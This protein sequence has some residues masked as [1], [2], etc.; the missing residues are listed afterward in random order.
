MAVNVAGNL[1]NAAGTS[2]PSDSQSSV[3][4]G[5]FGTRAGP[6][7]L[8]IKAEDSANDDSIYNADDAITVTFSEPTNQ[9]SVAT[10]ANLNSLFT[11]SQVLGANYTGVWVNPFTLVITVKNS[12]GAEPPTVGSLT[13]TVKSSGNLKN[14]AGTSLAST[15]TSPVLSGSFGNKSGPSIISFVADD[16]DNSDSVFSNG[17]TLTI[18]FD[19]STNQ[20]SVATKADIDRLFTFSQSIGDDY[21]GAWV[22]PNTMTITIV[23]ASAEEPPVVGDLVATVHESGNLQAAGTSLPSASVS[24]ALTGTFGTFVQVTQVA[25]GGTAYSILPSGITSSITLPDGVSGVITVTRTTALDTLDTSSTINFLGTVVDITPSEGASCLL[26]CD[27]SFDFTQED[28]NSQGVGPFDVKIYHDKN[29][30]GDFADS[31]EIL[32]TTITQLDTNLFRASAFIDS[33]SKFAVGGIKAL[34][35]AFNAGS[36]GHGNAP[37]LGSASLSSLGNPNDGLGGIISN[38]DLNSLTTTRMVKTGEKLVL[39]FDLAEDQGINNINHVEL[40]INN[41]GDENIPSDT[42]IVFEKYHALVVEDPHKLFSSA[43]FTILEK[44]ATNFVLKFD[45]TF[46]KPMNMSDVR[47]LVWDLDKNFAQKYYHNA[48]TVVAPEPK[49]TLSEVVQSESQLP[50]WI[51]NNA[52]WW[53]KGKITD[54][55]FVQGIQYLIQQK[56]IVVPSKSSDSIGYASTNHIPSWIKNNAGWWSDNKISDSE[57]VSAIQYLMSNGIIRISGS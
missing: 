7:I 4:A 55:D 19:E 56:I 15:F 46:A 1:K 39:R 47:L 50:V 57:F 40:G 10:K 23:D 17:D 9:P 5:N 25:D 38:V 51:K 37:S 36:G 41:K 27:V 44:D 30:D 42:K 49:Q 3:L 29:D 20:P 26:G 11:F 18:R 53:S 52:G 35:S 48:L 28:A 24:P 2:L 34:V 33:N 32:S 12:T 45:M 43:E 21:T 54:T 31:G 6:S 8:S 13:L 14:A 22:Q 16:P